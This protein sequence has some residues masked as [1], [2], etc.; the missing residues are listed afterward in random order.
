[1]NVTKQI[2]FENGTHRDLIYSWSTNNPTSDIP[3]V[4]ESKEASYRIYS[5]FFLEDGDFIRLK[6][7]TLGYTLP[8]NVCTKLGISNWRFYIS[9]QNLLTLSKY[10]GFDPEVGGNGLSTKGIDNGS[11]PVSSQVRIGTQLT[12]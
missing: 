5:D 12:F 9:G 11:Y 4:Y 3:L 7:V 8:K 10:T 2:A 1:M 6:N